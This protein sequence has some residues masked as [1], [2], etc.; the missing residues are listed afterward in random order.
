MPCELFAFGTPDQVAD[1]VTR[2]LEDVGP[3]GVIIS[4]GCDIP[5]DAKPENVKA[6]ADAAHAFLTTHP[7]H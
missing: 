1:Y 2:M 4:S 7:Q 6:M 3:W 5:S